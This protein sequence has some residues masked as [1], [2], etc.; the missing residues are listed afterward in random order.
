MSFQI[1][2]VTLKHGIMLAPMAG[3][4][5]YAFR[6]LSIRCGAEYTVSEMVSAKAMHYQDEKTATLARIRG[7]ELPMAILAGQLHPAL[8]VGYGLLMGLGMLAAALSSMVAAVMRTSGSTLV[9][10]LRSWIILSLQVR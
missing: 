6:R 9:A 3:V 2:N 8:E 1:G 4:T 5:D 10:Q 7:G